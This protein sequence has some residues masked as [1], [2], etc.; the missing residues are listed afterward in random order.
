MLLSVA[1]WSGKQ[2]C[3]KM[4]FVG[5]EAQSCSCPSTKELLHSTDQFKVYVLIKEPG[6]CLQI[7]S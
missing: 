2:S 7:H 5:L 4:K 6:V 3:S 1:I